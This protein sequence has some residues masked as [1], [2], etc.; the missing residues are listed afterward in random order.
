MILAVALVAPGLA[1]ANDA[2]EHA[3]ELAR[4]AEFE[5]ALEAL[6]AAEARG[7][8][9]RD[10]LVTL[11]QERALVRFALGDHDAM[12]EDVGRLAV[13][14]PN[15]V[16]PPTSP[17]QIRAAFEEQR[18]GEALEVEADAT[19]TDASVTVRVRVTGEDRGLARGLRVRARAGDAPY[20]ARE[21]SEVTFAVPRDVALDWYAE[22]LG[23]GGAVI[24]SVGD[25]ERP[26]RAGP[27]APALA[28]GQAPSGGDDG[29][30][31]GLAL[32][33]AGLAV[34]AAVAVGVAVAMSSGDP[35]TV[36]SG[37]TVER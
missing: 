23:P 36:I 31:W 21:G 25:A 32:G 8:L 19:R 20:E 12:R 24:A 2:L 28:L 14:A 35:Q 29:L 4:E 26:R 30:V 34:V 22:L 1:R 6:A 27:E 10:E 13:L 18:L 16:L 37:P 11:L 7:P 33:G 9:T 17:P 5:A 3:I 15:L